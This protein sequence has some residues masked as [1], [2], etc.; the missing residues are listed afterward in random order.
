MF[1]LEDGRGRG[2]KKFV[3]FCGHHEW[4]TPYKRALR[5]SSR[6]INKVPFCANKTRWNTDLLPLPKGAQYSKNHEQC[7]KS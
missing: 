3:I 7:N 6:R 5:R 1:I 2:V 4:M